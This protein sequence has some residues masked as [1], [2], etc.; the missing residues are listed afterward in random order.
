MALALVIPTDGDIYPVEFEIGNSYDM[1]SKGVGGLIECVEISKG[2]DMWIN[3][4]G[5]MY[6]LDYNVRATAFYWTRHP[7]AFMRDV[8]VGDVVLTGGVGEEGETLG[9]SPAQVNW[10]AEY[11]GPAQAWL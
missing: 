9:L 4:E 1:L 6:G 3:E 2:I 10:L 5:K 7:A 11:S 8:I